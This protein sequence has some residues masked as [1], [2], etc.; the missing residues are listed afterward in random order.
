MLR[1]PISATKKKSHGSPGPIVQ[2]VA[3]MTATKIGAAMT[4]TATTMTV[5]ANPTIAAVV[6]DQRAP[7]PGSLGATD[8]KTSLGVEQPRAKHNYSAQF[9]KLLDGPCPIHKGTKH[10]MK[11][12]MG[13]AK[14]YLEE[15]EKRPC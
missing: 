4:A 2:C 5:H 9:D 3:M 8:L 10:T 6:I 14:A 13:L 7:N 11:E 12:C 1:R 15:E